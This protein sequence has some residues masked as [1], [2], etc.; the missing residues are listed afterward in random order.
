MPQSNEINDLESGGTVKLPTRSL[1]FPSHQNAACECRATD[2]ASTLTI[3]VTPAPTGRYQSRLDGDDR[4]LCISGTPFF[5]AARKLVAQGHD[6][7]TILLLR[8]EGSETECLRAKLGMAASLTV[9]ET[10][11]GPQLR[12]WKPFSTLAVP[13]SIAPND[14]VAT[15][16]APQSRE[17]RQ[18]KALI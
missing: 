16:L 14:Q 11:Y 5:D 3:I 6:Y 2:S 12:R 1:G 4:V 9:E 8:H 15:T 13:P 7:D 17:A 18:R 10:G